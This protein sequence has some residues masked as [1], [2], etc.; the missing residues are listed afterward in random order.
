MPRLTCPNCDTGFET[1][2]ARHITCPACGSRLDT[3]GPD[4]LRAVSG[5]SRT[6]EKI[7]GRSP[8]DAGDDLS[9]IPKP[10]KEKPQRQRTVV[11]RTGSN[12]DAAPKTMLAVLVG[13][14]V[15]GCLLIGI[16][17][18]LVWYLGARP[19]VSA[20]STPRNQPPPQNFD[21]PPP[22]MAGGPA[23]QPPTSFGP[24]L[25]AGSG[26][27]QE[28]VPTPRGILPGIDPSEFPQA[29][30]EIGGRVQ[31]ILDL[32]P[33]GFFGPNGPGGGLGG[34]GFPGGGPSSPD[35]PVPPAGAM[36][37][38]LSSLRV[39]TNRLQLDFDFGNG[40]AQ[41]F[42]CYVLKA[43]N[44]SIEVRPV[45]ISRGRGTMT[46]VI[47]GGIPAGPVQIWLERRNS[48]LQGSGERISNILSR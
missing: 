14:T 33:P 46:S 29:G 45:G 22:G 39:D 16:I 36:L 38:T 18:T 25:F 8:F 10:K 27:R 7:G 42:D 9:E 19:Q 40:I 13:S 3:R 43:T 11:I 47:P 20:D 41:Q 30:A 12:N 37:V 6:T 28:A 35:A 24:G 44:V 48:S 26:P 23:N 17:I 31:D 21:A 15:L 4:G 2:G 32:F 34:G 5:P 1:A